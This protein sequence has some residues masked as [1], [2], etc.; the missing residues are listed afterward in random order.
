LNEQRKEDS[1]VGYDCLHLVSEKG[2]ADEALLYRKI[3]KIPLD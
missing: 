3:L 1:G 2:E